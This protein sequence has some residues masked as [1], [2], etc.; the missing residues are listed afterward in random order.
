MLSKKTKIFLFSIL[1]FIIIFLLVNIFWKYQ[2][3]DVQSLKIYDRSWNLLVD[4]R[5]TYRKTSYQSLDEVPQFIKD[6][7]LFREDRRFYYHFGIDPIA[8]SRAAYQNILNFKFFQWASTIDQQSVKLSSSGFKRWVYQKFKELVLSVNVNFHYSKNDILLYY[9]NNLQFGNWVVGFKSAC[10]IY[11]DKDCESLNNWQLI[12]LFSMSKFPG[13]KDVAKYASD[14]AK[15]YGISDYSFENFDKIRT[16]LWF[17]V[18]KKAPHF[19]DYVLSQLKDWNIEKWNININTSLD[20][21]VYEKIQNILESHRNFLFLKSSEDAC[22]IVLDANRNIISMNVLRPYNDSQW[23][24]VN[25][26]TSK[27]QVWSA[28]KPFLYALAFK[29]L[30]YNKDTKIKDEPV[31]YFLDNWWKYE[32]KNFDMKYHGEVTLAWALWSS[33]NIPAVK[34]LHDVWLDTYWSFLKEIWNMVGATTNWDEDFNDYGL[35]LAL[36]S[37]EISVLDFAKMYT[38]FLGERLRVKGKSNLE[39]QFYNKYATQLSQ[40]RQILSE[41]QNRLISFPLY[42]WFDVPWTFVKSGTSRSF[43]DGW[44]CWWKND[45]IVCVWAWN[46]DSKPSKDWWYNTAWVIWNNIIKLF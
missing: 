17:Y 1:W 5:Q 6:I 21:N 41:N 45:K 37:K 20:Y 39:Q 38:I 3:K 16:R 34:L 11:F 12:Y 35:S 8:V 36:W 26:C 44:V 22:A 9:I 30:W 42:N 19:V 13:K 43:V 23:G 25:G 33:L 27:R 32:P 46:Y 7:T 40:V 10:G 4:V 28:M 29:N 15:R 14:F 24:N 31:E 18:D 2:L